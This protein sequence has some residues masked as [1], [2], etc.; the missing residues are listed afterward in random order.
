MPDA[1]APSPRRRRSSSGAGRRRPL[2]RGSIVAGAIALIE[3]DGPEALTMRRLGGRLGVE[4]MALYHHFDGRG[5]LL[6]AIA[7]DLLAPLDQ[8][9][10]IDDWRVACRHF[11]IALRD[12]AVA[13][14]AT[15]R[16]V[17]LQPFDSASALR[18][19]ERLLEV[20]VGAGFPAPRSLAIY[21]AIVSY[22]R[23]YALAE[24]TGFTVDAARPSG[25]ARL[26]ALP[27]G[28]FPVLAG[29]ADELVGLL[30]D[31]AYALGLDAM[32]RGIDD[33]S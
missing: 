17:G 2:T 1:T 7:D 33:H 8:L 13:R 14:P 22:A 5:Q 29:R 20:L 12:I 21:R 18:P 10:V 32:L 6:S 19:V 4:A 23:G 28:E 16:L 24:A 25:R 30:A 3:R 31:D 26:A 27:P 11:A 15:F 9:E